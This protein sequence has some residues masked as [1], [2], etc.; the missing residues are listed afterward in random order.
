MGALPSTG[1]KIQHVFYDFEA[2]QNTR[3]TDEAKLHVPKLVGVQ[4][5]CS[6]CEDVKDGGGDC[7]R[8]GKWKHSFWEVRVA[9]LLSY[10]C[11]PRP[12]ANKFLAIA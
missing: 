7:V 2:T 4:Q 5:S 12:W 11:E 8:C 3:Y 1:D 9:D 6:R 10:L